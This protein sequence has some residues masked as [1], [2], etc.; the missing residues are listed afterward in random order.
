KRYGDGRGELLLIYE[1]FGDQLSLRPMLNSDD[2]KQRLDWYKRRLGRDFE[3]RG[4]QNL[5]DK[6]VVSPIEQIF[7]MEWELLHA[8]DP[9]TFTLEPQ[10]KVPVGDR[11]YKV[12]FWLAEKAARLSWVL[13]WTATNFTRNRRPSSEGTRRANGRS[14]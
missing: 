1:M 2:V 7:I 8:L 14:S 13:N 3:R 11:L 5:F 12:D 4:N 10:Y 6:S 9:I